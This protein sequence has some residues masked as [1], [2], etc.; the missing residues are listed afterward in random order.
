VDQASNWLLCCSKLYHRAPGVVVASASIGARA[1]QRAKQTANGSAIR[2]LPHLLYTVLGRTMNL[3]D[4][5][6]S[7][8]TKSGCLSV[9]ILVMGWETPPLYTQQPR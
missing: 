2:R 9:V 6:A 3:T 7:Q 1:A 4:F 5:V 8:Q